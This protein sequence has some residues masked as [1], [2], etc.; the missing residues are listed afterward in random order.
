MQQLAGGSELAPAYV[1]LAI[2]VACAY[3]CVAPRSHRGVCVLLAHVPADRHSRATCAPWACRPCR[4]GR[5]KRVSSSGC[6][7]TSRAV[8]GVS[9]GVS[10]ALRRPCHRAIARASPGAV[11]RVT[12]ASRTPTL[13]SSTSARH[14]RAAVPQQKCEL[15][16]HRCLPTCQSGKCASSLVR[17]LQQSS[18]RALQLSTPCR[19]GRP[20][21]QLG[22]YGPNGPPGRQAARG[23]RRRG[24][25][26]CISFTSEL[27]LSH[28]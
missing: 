10:R 6:A 12:Q 7:V 24:A 25:L 27:L 20:W 23:D 5:K 8:P 1:T 2:G 22:H 26:Q 3:K 4:A 28:Y 13:H 17:V 18:A 11:T 9:S 14:F 16:L 15:S 21:L 19:F